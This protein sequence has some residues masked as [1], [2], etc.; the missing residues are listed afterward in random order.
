M[1]VFV[2]LFLSGMLLLT[3]CND[4]RSGLVGKVDY[5][6]PNAPVEMTFAVTTRPQ[7]GMSLDYALT[8]TL[9]ANVDDVVITVA[10]DDA[11]LLLEHPQMLHLGARERNQQDVLRVICQ[12]QRDGLFYMYVSATLFMDGQQQSSSFVIPVEVGDGV[13]QL[14]QTATGVVLDDASGER[15]ISL[16]ADESLRP[17]R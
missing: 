12:P 6:K 1:N 4:S 11:L 13:S 14:P 16:P 2:K 17:A 10:A 9:D 3:G 7:V 5:A 8:F 15:I